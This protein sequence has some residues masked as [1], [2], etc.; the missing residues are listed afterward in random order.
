MSKTIDQKVVE[1]QFD[2]RN[3]EK[4]VATT[5]SS[6]DKLK[7]S[8]NFTGASKGLED[9][10]AAA[11]KVDMNG[12]GTAVDTVNTK[13]SSLQVMAVTALANITNSAVNAGKNIVSA[14]T[15]DPILTGFQEY[16]TQMNAVQTILANTQSKGSTIDDVNAALNELNKYADQTI[17]NFTEMTRNIGTFT[18][19][20]VDLDKSVTS[21]KGIANL[22]AV[23]GSNAQQASTAMYQLSQA[24]AAGRVS[25]MDWNSVV[26][27]GM[28]GEV[29]QTALIRT[30][31]A[32][33]TGVDEAIKKYG[34]FRESLTKGQWLTADV[35]TETLTQL[36]GA[37]TEADLIAQGYTEQQAADIVKL[38]ETAVGAATDIK[39]FTQMWDTMKEAVQ[40]GWAQTWQTVIGDF[41]ESK[42]LFS[43]INGVIAPLIESA[44]T[45]R[46]E[47]LSGAFD[48]NWDK[49]IKQVNE[50]G[51]AT[52]DFSNE[53]EKT[54]RSSVKN[55]DEIIEKSGSLEKAFRDGSL[56]SDLIIKTLRNMAGETSAV[57]GTTEEMTGKLEHFQKVVDEVWNG[58]YKN[59]EERVKALTAAGYDYAQVQDL[60][61]KTVDG[62]KLTLED[63]TDV[64]LKNIGYTDEEVKAL[65]DLADQAEKTGT[66]LN[67]LIE[68]ITKPSGRE[69]LWEGLI[70]ILESVIDIFGAVKEAWQDIFPPM[71]SN[72]L[73]KIIEGFNSLTE[74]MVPSVDTLDKLTR[75]FK[76]LFAV[77]DIFTTITGGAVKAAFRLISEVL[78][79][80]DIDILDFTAT[81]GD[82]A[83]KLRDFLLDNE[84]VSKGF[85]L[86]ATG[87]RKI[88]EA[89]KSLVEYIGNLEFV[90]NAIQSLKDG[91]E[92]FPEIAEW[93][94]EGLKN[95]FSDGISSIPK[96][97]VDLGKK[98]LEAI[99]GVLGIQSPS[100]EMYEV[101]QFTIQGLLNGLVEGFETVFSYVQKA[102]SEIID[103]IINLPWGKIAAVVLSFGFVY[104]I[105]RVIGIMENL[106]SP[107]DGFGDVLES[108]S[109]VLDGFAFNLKAEAIKSIAI[110]IGILAASI[111]LMTLVDTGKLWASI[112]ALA[113]LAAVL[114]TL[115]VAIGKW[116]PKSGIQ[117]GSVAAGLLGISASVLIMAAAAK[118][119]DSLDPDKLSKTL[120]AFGSIVAAMAALTV[121]G[122]IAGDS[123]DKVG[124]MLLKIS[125]AMILMV[126]VMKLVSQ[127]SEEEM[128]KGAATILAF[129]G[130]TSALMVLSAFSGK[131]ADKFGSMML[132]LSVSFGVMAT[133][134]KIIAG[135][136]YEDVIKGVAT[137]TAFSAITSIL[138]I[139][140]IFPGKNADK[141]G[142]LMLK[143]SVSF[144]AMAGVIK[145]LSGIS[146]EDI[147]KGVA[148]ITALGGLMVVLTTLFALIN[149]IGKK[150]A[151]NVSS[152]LLSISIS[153]GILAGVVAILS[154]IDVGGLAKGLTAVGIL[155]AIVSAMLLATKNAKDV[156]KNMLTLSVAIAVMAAAI[157]VLSFIDPAPLAGA[158]A[159]LSIVMGMFALI[160][161][162]GSNINSSMG[163]LITLTVV[164]GL[165]S[166]ALILVAQ[167]PIE[168]SLGA[169][170]SLSILL[171]SISAS[172]TI[173][174]KMDSV[175][176]KSIAAAA[177][178]GLVMLELGGVLAAMKAMGVD[179]NTL[180][181]AASL[182]ILLTSVSA[183]VAILSKVGTVSPQALV[184]A[185]GVAAVLLEIGSIIALLKTMGVDEVALE[186]ALSLSALLAAVTGVTAVL[187]KLGATPGTLKAATEGALALDAVV[188]I[189]TGLVA[190]IGGISQIPGFDW[191]ISEG[192]TALAS[193][194]SAIGGFVGGLVGGVVGGA[195]A[196]ITSGLPQVGTDLSTFMG[197]LQPFITG[198]KSISAE[199]G[200]MDGVTSIAGMVLA[201]SAA[202]FINGITGLFSIFTGESSFEDLG[203]DLQSFGTAVVGFSN[204]VSG[205]I[206]TES[207]TAAASAGQMLAD[208]YNALPKEG[209]ILQDFLGTQDL[210]GFGS[211]LK[212][213]GTGIMDFAT[214]VEG[215]DPNVVTAAANAGM[216]LA[217]LNKNIP[218][219]DGIL[220][221]FLGEQDLGTWGSKLKTLG[222]GIKDFATEIEGLDP[223]VVTNAAN[224][225]MALADLNNNIPKQD[226]VLQDFLGEK[227][228]ATWG[229]QLKALGEG[230]MDFAT[231]VEGLD[232]AVVTNAANAGMAL[233]ALNDAIPKNEGIFVDIFGGKSM[234]TFG[235]E[236]EAFGV[237][238]AKYSMWMSVVDADVVQKTTDAADSLVELSDSLG[239]DKLFVKEKTLDDFGTQLS[240]FGDSFSAY[241]GKISSMDT[242]KLSDVIDEVGD[243]VDLANGMDELDTSGMTEFGSALK[244]MGNNGIEEF[245]SAFEDSVSDIQKTAKDMLD[246]FAEATTDNISILTNAYTKVINDLVD[247]ISDRN[248]NFKTLGEDFMTYISYGIDAKKTSVETKL[249]SAVITAYSAARS[250]Y[251]NFYSAG[252]Y[253]I[254]GFVLGML[255]HL[256]E[257]L[258]KSV[259]M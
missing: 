15:I 79:V 122:S 157:A 84:L 200:L 14:L 26:N 214:E 12:L 149:K 251:T 156:H 116:G 121:V 250:Q 2:N 178:L 73:Y 93:A 18:A 175:S 42:E 45:A 228:L 148:T 173:L 210:A 253:I 77:L 223:A 169:A 248:E 9:V 34:T 143:L 112:G 190:A 24:L 120:T 30:A 184:A 132:K 125:V 141:F 171:V 197:N 66:P 233:A 61:N 3:F 136:S 39:T 154:L 182:S 158:S 105:H 49:L 245:I 40:S 92:S 164:V 191:L 63:L 46:N 205:N 19:A 51:I 91:F 179:E 48:S 102:G 103:T 68:N 115:S 181:N 225:G 22:A 74:E 111:I 57:A 82:A 208:L 78:G 53:L 185:A 212:D 254:D 58:D 123:A 62:H 99:K 114:G 104:E 41:E 204:I 259:H 163:V 98:I 52:E 76:G 231:E 54:A 153:I 258:W 8:L 131:N 133:V 162:S 90:Q 145:L 21:I 97:L 31:R 194:G 96:L 69:L 224:A 11:K 138:M 201:L 10:G 220:Q 177:A 117:F 94:I 29:F 4:N 170:A 83:V 67:E 243:L 44:S 227:D 36:S 95:G 206:D 180:E 85:E 20:G 211:K 135:I 126:A 106:T 38:A 81:L 219:S 56:S 229:S 17:Y 213:L 13:F 203:T 107:L 7:K 33:G 127:L 155:G 242:D 59:G 167:L 256:R 168:E 72:T 217:E 176:A 199:E 1:M 235:E 237:S 28:G 161:K 129:S 240:K 215:L 108:F 60:V 195:I 109:K 241:Y 207:V 118:Q 166:T 140:S 222:T 255:I 247:H 64:Q 137:L 150:D 71:T 142:S 218:K 147:V 236:L 239:D 110:A 146:E 32:M 202:E 186:T 249:E 165:L 246:T 196:G 100:T 80:A 89:F 188:L 6:V 238:F 43:E 128:I 144:V 230:I 257:G 192:A 119:L 139:F 101:G 25:L 187:A 50:A 193:I 183:A 55:F 35:L 198:V 226:G 70:N 113:A 88:I 86:A 87:I 23:S 232:P 27:A 172:L 151:D 174:S 75:T 47:L 5:M 216:A 130:I 221:D 37:Y 252:A 152:T 124:K 134:V 160:L 244:E 16:E 209:G 159:A 234:T 189:I 65:R